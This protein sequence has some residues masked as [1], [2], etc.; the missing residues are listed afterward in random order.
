MDCKVRV[1]GNYSLF[2][3]SNKDK[4]IIDIRKRLGAIV[5]IPSIYLGFTAKE[6]MIEQF[7]LIGNP[8]FDE[9]YELLRLVNLENTGKKKAKN[10]SLRN[11]AKIRNCYDFSQ[12]S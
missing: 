3:V 6:N 9:I 4:K 5:E 8:D 10:F 12:S 1:F 7:K 11:E 2:G